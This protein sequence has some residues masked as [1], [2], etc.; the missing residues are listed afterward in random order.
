MK[1]ETKKYDFE[2]ALDPVSMSKIFEQR[3]RAIDEEIH[4]LERA[5]YAFKSRDRRQDRRA[6]VEQSERQKTY[7]ACQDALRQSWLGK[8]WGEF[9]GKLAAE[10]K[11][12]D[13]QI[14]DLLHQVQELVTQRA[15][16]AAMRAGCTKQY[17]RW[18]ISSGKQAEGQFFRQ[19]DTTVLDKKIHAVPGSSDDVLQVYLNRAFRGE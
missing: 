2:S 19:L 17:G 6:P 13:T 4:K 8:G 18:L 9:T 14:L 10:E 7:S 16:L 1:T 5:R 12:I 11:Q 3:A 15:M